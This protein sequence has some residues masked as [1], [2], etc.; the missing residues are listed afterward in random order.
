MWF[1]MIFLFVCLFHR[2]YDMA[3]LINPQPWL[4]TLCKKYWQLEP[5]LE[6]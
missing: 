2:Q 4:L 1:N 6:H 3:F 5:R